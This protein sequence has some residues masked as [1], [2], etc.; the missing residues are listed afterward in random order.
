MTG[1]I[2]KVY[3]NV[4]NV[5]DL[6]MSADDLVN[7]TLI[8]KNGAVGQIQMDMVSPEYRRNLELVYRDAIIYWDYVSGKLYKKMN[9]KVLL[10]DETPKTFER[11]TM[12][13]NQMNHFIN[14]VKGSLEAPLCSLESGI[15]A[16]KIA[17]AV[18]LSSELDRVVNLEEFDL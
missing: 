18:K 7:I 9:G 4:S 14:R 3:G 13:L 8:N 12:F 2:E 10:L 15:D 5:S 11:N 1:G 6:E 16:Q 17:E